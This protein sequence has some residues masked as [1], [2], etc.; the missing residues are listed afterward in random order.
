MSKK[1][2]C[3]GFKI[4]DDTL[5]LKSDGTLYAAG[6][7]GGVQPDWNQNDSTALDYIKNRP[8]YAE[9]IDGVIFSNDSVA[10]SRGM[11]NLGEGELS[12]DSIYTV[13][14]DGTVYN[15][16]IPFGGHGAIVIG[17]PRNAMSDAMPFSIV[18]YGGSL[19]I[20][21]IS[22]EGTHS[23][24]IYEKGPG[25]HTID[26]SYTNIYE[27]GALPF[28]ITWDGNTGGLDSFTTKG[29]TYYKVSSTYPEY[30]RVIGCRSMLSDGQMS[31]SIINGGSNSCY[32]LGHA[33]VALVKTPD[34]LYLPGGA[35]VKAPSTGIYFEKNDAEGTYQTSLTMY[36]PGDRTRL[37]I[38][39]PFG[40]EFSIMVDEDG[41]LYTK[42]VMS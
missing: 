30:N 32:M 24:I 11:A 35:R 19:M 21:T 18:G 16:L 25:I 38:I 2:G 17:S 12:I 26:A 29:K 1:I 41:K 15:N 39:S 33:I 6:G 10:F 23:I 31:L 40:K 34:E 28:E 13:T 4:D 20:A 14:F 5:K 36:L 22:P 27:N 42:E 37:P 7:G 3:G 8:F 9:P